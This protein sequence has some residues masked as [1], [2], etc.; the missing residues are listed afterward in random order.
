MQLGGDEALYIALVLTLC[1]RFYGGSLTTS[2]HLVPIRPPFVNT[3]QRAV[4]FD[5]QPHIQKPIQYA[6]PREGD[7][8]IRIGL[9]V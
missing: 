6:A 4:Y 7:G 1:D 9:A 5:I 3:N 8:A 2:G